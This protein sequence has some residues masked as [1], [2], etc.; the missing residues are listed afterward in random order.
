MNEYVLVVYLLGV[1][2]QDDNER[3]NLSPE[4]IKHGIVPADEP[5]TESGR[6]RRQRRD[7]QGDL[8]N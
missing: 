3:E 6:Q 5:R 4:H 2:Y 8:P 7:T 1:R